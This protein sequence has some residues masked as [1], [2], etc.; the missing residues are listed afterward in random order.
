Y[1]NSTAASNSYADA[2]VRSANPGN[3]RGSV[4][5]AHVCHCHG[6]RRA[7]H[8]TPN[9]ADNNPT[10][11]VEGSESP[12]LIINPRPTPRRN[13]NPVAVAVRSPTDDC[14]V[15]EPNVAVL[16]ILAPP[17]VIVQVVVTNDVS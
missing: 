2:E 6:T 1:A 10:A 12:R 7:W 8:P 3:E 9:A 15:R 16:G 11:I 4:N 5:R 17:A 13:P 14:G